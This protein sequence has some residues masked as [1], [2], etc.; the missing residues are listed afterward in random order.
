MTLTTP[1]YVETSDSRVNSINV[2]V[3]DVSLV[4]A[5]FHYEHG[6]EILEKENTSFS[7]TAECLFPAKWKDG[8]RFLTRSGK[9]YLYAI[10]LLANEIQTPRGALQVTVAVS[11]D[12][13]IF[14]LKHQNFLNQ[15]AN[16]IHHTHEIDPQEV[17]KIGDKIGIFTKERSSISRPFD[18][19]TKT[20]TICHIF[21]HSPNVLLSLWRA[22]MLHVKTAICST[23]DV[24]AASYISYFISCCALP[25]VPTEDSSFHIELAQTKNFASD[26]W[27]FCAVTH[28]LL[29]MNTEVPVR[30]MQNYTIQYVNQYS[31]LS[32][33]DGSII[34]N[35]QASLSSYDDLNVLHTL[36][37]FT[38]DVY[39]LVQKRH[40]TIEDL[41][42]ARVGKRSLRFIKEFA[43]SQG[44]NPEIDV[45]DICCC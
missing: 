34:Q 44:T 16:Y 38:T 29:Q 39:S 17:R 8:V 23:D 30:L 25:V 22:R 43:K 28:P 35:L 24:Q 1:L 40:I 2:D 21:E 7:E 42:Q 15:T 6:P 11:S 13:A 45:S 10:C 20:A 5:Q 14:S 32:N 36:I 31:W 4:I 26:D 33:G 37:N 41:L 19:F 27:S 12:K 3:S 18:L 9:R